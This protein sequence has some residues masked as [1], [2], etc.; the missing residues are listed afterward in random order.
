MSGIPQRLILGPLLFNIS[1]C[2]LFLTI[3]GNCFTNY[4]DDTTPYVRVNNAEEVVSEL[5]AI[6]QK[7]FTW[8]TLNEMKANLD[9]CHLL[10]SITDVFN[11]NFAQLWMYHSRALKN[12][13]NRLHDRCLQIIYNDKISTFKELLEKDNSVSVHYRNIEALETESYKVANEMSPEKMNEIFQLRDKSHYN[14]RYTSEFIIPPIH[15]V[16]H[17]SE[18]VSYLGPKIWDLI[19][20]LIRQIDTFSGFKKAIKKW[21]PTNCPCRICKTYIPSAGFL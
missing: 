5:K 21:K 14:L 13:A 4:A 3:E 17:G 1:L 15:S 18:S 7:L 19:S 9:K 8:F 20:S 6:T 2:D 11:F 12:K 10:L 16:Y